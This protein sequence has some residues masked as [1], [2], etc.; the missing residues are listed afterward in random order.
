LGTPSS[1]CPGSRVLAVRPVPVDPGGRL[2]E[3]EW[4]WRGG[5]MSLSETWAS[6]GR[7]VCKL[8]CVSTR[9]AAR[10]AA[11][12]EHVRGKRVWSP[13]DVRKARGCGQDF[14]HAA[15]RCVSCSQGGRPCRRE[16]RV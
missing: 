12:A 10:V 14:S 11:R 15:G 1:P 5:R 4:G 8:V 16:G 7:H 9:Q 2:R 13:Y 6:S 3:A